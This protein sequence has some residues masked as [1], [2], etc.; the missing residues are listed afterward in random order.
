MPLRMRG[1][2]ELP[3]VRAMNSR[4]RSQEMVERRRQAR[5]P[6]PEM[7]PAQLAD[8]TTRAFSAAASAGS[9]LNIPEFQ[10]QITGQARQE[11]PVLRTGPTA[12]ERRG[13]ETPLRETGMLVRQ[14]DGSHVYLTGADALQYSDMA[15][16]AMGRPPASGMRVSPEAA[17]AVASNVRGGIDMVRESGQERGRQIRVRGMEPVMEALGRYNLGE[18]ASLRQPDGTYQYQPG[19]EELSQSQLNLLADQ[20]PYDRG[21]GI[22]RFEDSPLTQ[23]GIGPLRGEVG[24]LGGLARRALEAQQQAAD[25]EQ[26]A[27]QDALMR[28]QMYSPE[29]LISLAESQQPFFGSFGAEA[30]YTPE[31]IGARGQELL[32]QRNRMLEDQIARRDELARQAMERS[33]G[34]DIE[35]L[36]PSTELS[37]AREEAQMGRNAQR[38]AAEVMQYIPSD[39]IEGIQSVTRDLTPEERLRVRDLT[40]LD[41]NDPIARLIVGD[42]TAGLDIA[43][44]DTLTAISDPG[45]ILEVANSM[46]DVWSY[47]NQAN[48]LATRPQAIELR[49]QLLEAANGDMVAARR[50]L[51][52]AL[53][54]R[55][56][57]DT[58]GL[59]VDGIL[60]WEVG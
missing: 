40:G 11:E 55:L 38:A 48:F 8:L 4:Q 52:Q 9:R 36:T 16:V 43:V 27:E 7:D 56:D 51:R 31:Q 44:N 58:A 37:L 5:G 13:M 3:R 35:L 32:S 14:A 59:L 33:R 21:R 41:P 60:N 15:D 23:S 17:R 54:S 46:P 2:S 10:R 47:S 39:N 42:A 29:A 30:R 53:L 50:A 12:N 34:G 25:V 22:R 6:Q 24:R 1:P 49:A 45:G 20:T 18:S 26:L 57:E 19:N 28:E